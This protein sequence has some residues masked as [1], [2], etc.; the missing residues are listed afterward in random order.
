MNSV[1]NMY[2]T[3]FSISK[4]SIMGVTKEGINKNGKKNFENVTVKNSNLM[5]VIHLYIEEAP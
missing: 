2:G 5:K 3:P 1:S 4:K